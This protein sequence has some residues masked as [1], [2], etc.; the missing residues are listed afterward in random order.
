MKHLP[1]LALLLLAACAKPELPTTPDQ[2]I[3][4]MVYY[5]DIWGTDFADPG[6]VSDGDP[7]HPDQTR[8]LPARKTED[9]VPNSM[10]HSATVDSYRF[11]EQG[12]LVGYWMD[13]DTLL[14]V[15]AHGRD[16]ILKLA[17]CRFKAGLLS[18]PSTVGYKKWHT[19]EREVV[20]PIAVRQVMGQKC[21][22]YKP[23][24]QLVVRADILPDASLGKWWIEM[25]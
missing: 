2:R 14:H 8:Q 20:R 19:A 23:G 24:D 9:I 21:G 1:I 22:I 18:Y 15:T 11:D 10:L 13:G 12:N 16:T 25:P 4:G 3:A 17:R 7:T 6:K 5:N